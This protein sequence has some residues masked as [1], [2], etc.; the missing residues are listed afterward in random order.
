MPS[1]VTSTPVGLPNAFATACRV[2]RSDSELFERCRQVLT[3][4]FGSDQIWLSVTRDGTRPERV[5][6]PE[7]FEDAVEIGRCTSGQTELVVLASRGAAAAMQAEAG[8][9]AL[10]LATVLEL[11][12]VLQERQAAL[13]DAVFQLRALRQVARLLASVHSTEETEHLVLDFMAEVFFAWWACLYRPE[14]GHYQ[15]KRYRA[16]DQTAAPGPIEGTLLDAA[17]P[18]D[19]LVADAQESSGLGALLPAGTELVVPLDAHNERLAVLLLGPRLNDAHYGQAERDLAGTLS[20]AAAMALKN[21]ELVERLASQATTDDLTGLPNRRALEQRLEAELSRGT[22][23]Q[24]KTTIALIDVDRFKLINDTLGH[25]AG[26]RYL[27]MIGQVLSRHVRA[28]D[29]V[30]RYGGDEF[31]VILTMTSAAEALTL[32]N[33]LQDGLQELASQHPEF[34]L[35]TLSFGVAEAPRHGRT[36]AALLAA[37]DTALYAAK[38]GGRNMVEIARDT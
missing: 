29:V 13:D 12:T 33:R 9:L 24:F 22:R 30:G 7:G 27:V 34:G 38:H 2:A 6:G 37:A 31:L 36:P 19:G 15:P 1:S 23:H 14:G 35:A 5:G 16:L 4:R 28:L 17:L 8:L 26:D 3:Q 32:V 25:A 20:F 21:A 18:S 10:G 11:R